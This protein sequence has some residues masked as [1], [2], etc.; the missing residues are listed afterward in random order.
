VRA[1]L[2]DWLDGL[3]RSLAGAPTD[4]QIADDGVAM[5]RAVGV[6]PARDSLSETA[7]TRI[8][9][10]VV[11]AYLASTPAAADR[12]SNLVGSSQ[13]HGATAR[14]RWAALSLSPRRALLTF[15][16]GAALFTGLTGGAVAESGP[17]HGLYPVRLAIETLTLPDARSDQRVTAQ[18][19]RLEVRVTEATE[20][21]AEGDVRGM[22]DALAAYSDTLPDVVELGDRSP[23]AALAA[24]TAL[25]R[26][27]Q[28]L[29]ALHDRVGATFKTRVQ[30]A[31]ADTCQAH[32]QLRAKANPRQATGPTTHVG[33]R[34]ADGSSEGRG[35]AAHPA[36]GPQ[37]FD[38]NDAPGAARC[39]Q[40]LGRQQ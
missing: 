9:D 12:R 39:R 25:R 8:R 35:A 4:G 23:A 27:A 1:R 6:Y 5:L 21:A 7:R 38:P 17:G 18:L 36:R 31:L 24:V 34:D 40:V 28:L 15:V 29:H 20:A 2:L 3:V 37:S 19:R 16:I 13:R 10:V 26:D 22:N 14:L 30:V 32:G 11:A 33:T